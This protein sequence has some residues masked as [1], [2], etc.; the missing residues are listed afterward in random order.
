M[1]PTGT[2]DVAGSHTWS[3]ILLGSGSRARY[4]SGVIS[5]ALSVPAVGSGIMSELGVVGGWLV[6]GVGLTHKKKKHAQGA[7]GEAGNPGLKSHL[8]GFIFLL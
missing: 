2:D 1:T 8:C 4:G 3:D 7:V 6:S 5:S